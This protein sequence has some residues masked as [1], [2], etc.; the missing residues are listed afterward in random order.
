MTKKLI[1]IREVQAGIWMVTVDGRV[2]GDS[3]I[4]ASAREARDAAI[5]DVKADPDYRELADIVRRGWDAD[6]AF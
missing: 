5:D 2:V 1:N 6:V 4:Y 3:K